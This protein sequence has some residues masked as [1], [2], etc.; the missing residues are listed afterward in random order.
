MLCEIKSL[1]KKSSHVLEP[2]ENGLIL[3]PAHSYYTKS[4]FIEDLGA[5]LNSDL[6]GYPA[7][8]R[9]PGEWGLIFPFGEFTDFGNLI[10]SGLLPD[11]NQACPASFQVRGTYVSAYFHG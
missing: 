11:S 10:A 5:S 2:Q 6:P 9:V 4:H 8:C 3:S 7:I 1:W